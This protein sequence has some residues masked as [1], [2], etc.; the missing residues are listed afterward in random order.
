MTPQKLREYENKGLRGKNQFMKRLVPH[1]MEKARHNLLFCTAV[2]DMNNSENAKKAINLPED[3]SAFDWVT[4]TAYYAMYHSALAA[5]ASVSYKSDNHTATIIALEAFFVDKNLLEMEFIDKLKQAREL[6]EEYVYK[7]K[8][9]K[10]QRETAQYGVTEQTGKDAAE[11]LLENARSFVDR[12][13]KLANR[14]TIS[15]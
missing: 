6:E 12:M 14:N 8:Q 7:L 13:E 15:G 5:L 11:K 2:W 4:I 10:R 1:F 9:A 3:F